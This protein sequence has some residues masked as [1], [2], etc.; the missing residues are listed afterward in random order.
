MVTTTSPE[1]H[2]HWK[3]ILLTSCFFT[4]LLFMPL[5]GYL[6]E[7]SPFT[8]D[9]TVEASEF[10]MTLPL[11][12]NASTMAPTIMYDY[13]SQYG[14]D[15]MRTVVADV[16]DPTEATTTTLNPVYSI[17]GV[18]YFPPDVK[19]NWPWVLTST[20][21]T[22]A[23]PLHATHTI[24]SWNITILTASASTSVLW[25]VPGNDLDRTAATSNASSTVY[26]VYRPVV[27]MMLWRLV[28]LLYRIGLCVWIFMLCTTH[29]YCHVYH[30]YNNLKTIPLH[31]TSP[32]MTRYE[33]VVGEPTCVV[34]S[35]PWLCWAFVVDICASTEYVGQACLRVCQTENWL[36][37]GLGLLYLGRTVWC[38][39]S[40]LTILNI[41]LKRCHRTTWFAPANTTVLAVA[42]TWA[43]GGIVTIQKQWPKVLDLYTSLF[44]P[45]D[46]DADV[47]MLHHIGHMDIALIMAVYLGMM[48][49]LP[50]AVAACSGVWNAVQRSTTKMPT[51]TRKTSFVSI[52]IATNRRLSSIGSIG[53]IHA[54]EMVVEVLQ[55]FTNLETH[56]IQ[57]FFVP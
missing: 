19:R 2:F 35:N 32:A 6:S 41:M 55:E 56:D 18:P 57:S 1:V 9:S 3:S 22:T 38:A 51:L 14:L 4:N 12:F 29:Y 15:V 27:K 39:Y 23:G 48:C 16:L 54:M 5:K 10:D 26:Y 52:L 25:V 33:I 20:N 44:V 37:F 11:L 45:Y 8:T 7:G 31:V 40:T 53:P 34:L 47:S 17:L 28:K 46:V 42:A 30:L 24:I 21:H 49:S 36:Y 13:D 43:G 50:F